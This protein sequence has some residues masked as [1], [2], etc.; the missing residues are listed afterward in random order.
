MIAFSEGHCPNLFATSYRLS[1]KIPGGE[2]SARA[3]LRSTRV[4]C[5]R[6]SFGAAFG[7]LQTGKDPFMD[8]QTF[9]LVVRFAMTIASL[10]EDRTKSK[11]LATLL[12]G[13][14]I[15]ARFDMSVEAFNF[16]LLDRGTEID[17]GIVIT[18]PD[19]LV[20]DCTDGDI[21]WILDLADEAVLTAAEYL[22]CERLEAQRLAEEIQF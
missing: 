14:S 5:E 20:T 18:F 6:G 12:G 7:N 8:L 10:I 3:P 1:K 4:L 2:R 15:E 9:S 22:E 11:A 17:L 13:R 19:L 21:R 16:V